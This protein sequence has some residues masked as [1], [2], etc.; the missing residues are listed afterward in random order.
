LRKRRTKL[1]KFLLRF[2][3][4]LLLFSGLSAVLLR[5]RSV[6]TYLAKRAG[7]A[8]GKELGCVVSVGGVEFDLFQ[9]I[10]LQDVYISDQ[11]GD[12]LIFAGAVSAKLKH[13]NYSKRI[14]DLFNV[15]LNR[16]FVHIGRYK[17]IPG[18]NID[19]LV[20]YLNGPPK[21]KKKS[22]KSPWFIKAG[23]VKLV[24]SR[25]HVF[26]Y[27][28]PRPKAGV[29]DD[30]YLEFNNIN[31]VCSDYRMLEDSMHFRAK[32]WALKER[33]GLTIKAMNAVC[34]IHNKGMDFDKLDLK[35]P[36]SH[37][38][39]DLHFK[40]PGFK[41]LD[42]FIHIAEWKANLKNSSV[43][44]AELSI[45]DE[46]LKGHSDKIKISTAISGT[47]DN[48]KL[49]K[50]DAVV[51]E[52]T[53]IKGD[54]LFEGLP[55][56]RTTYC[57][58]D[59]DE[60]S[61]DAQSLSKLLNGT[62]LPS[63]LSRLGEMNYS[64]KFAGQ[65]LDFKL[66]G[67]LQTGL[68]GISVDAFMNFKEGYARAEYAGKFIS[69]GFQA[70][71]LLGVTGTLDQMAFDMD[72]D[73]SGLTTETF[74]MKVNADF[75]MFELR[76]RGYADAEID[77]EI[78]AKNFTGT[79]I[80]DDPRLNTEFGGK[81]DF[82]EA[83]PV[84]DFTTVFKG[85]D[86]YELGIDSTHTLVYGKT[87]V[88][89]RG[90]DPINAEGKLDLENLSVHRLGKVYQY[91]SQQITKV[92]EQAGSSIVC[93][94]DILNGKISGNFDL[95]SLPTIFNNSIARVFPERI[96]PIPYQ[97][98]DSFTFI[99][100]IPETGLFA[101]Y[102]YPSLTTTGF[103]AQG[104]VNTARG[105]LN[106]QTEPLDACINGFTFKHLGF[107]SRLLDSANL[108]FRISAGSLLVNDSAWFN[109]LAL[110]GSACQSRA[111]FE[112]RIND[113]RWG[114]TIDIVAQSV[115]GKDS[116]Q[117]NLNRSTM[118]LFHHEWAA[119]KNA[120]VCI[121]EGGRVKFSELNFNG[122]NTYFELNGF[123]SAR[124]S[125]TLK[126]DF[127]NF[128]FENLKPFIPDHSLDSLD[129]V[130]NGTVY[131]SSL[132]NSPRIWGDIAGRKIKFSGFNYGDIDVS[133]EEHG[134]NG[135]LALNGKFIHGPLKGL[136]AKGSVAYEVRTGEEPLDIRFF[137]PEGT[138]VTAVQPFLKDIL[139]FSQGTLHADVHL[140]GSFSKPALSGF[141]SL[142]D[143][144]FMVDYLKTH[145]TGSLNLN[146]DNK[147]FYTTKPGKL[148]DE[149]GKNHALASL[150]ITHQNFANWYLDVRIDSAKNLKCLNTTAGDDDL[151]YGTGYVDGHCRIYG[152]FDQISMDIKLKT[153]KNTQVFLMY[154]DVEEN[155]VGGFVKFRDHFGKPTGK[156]KKVSSGSIYRINIELQATPDAEAQFVIDRRLGD[157]IRG[158]GEGIIRMLY[159][160][161]GQFF[162]FGNYS[163]TEGD[164]VFSLPGI[165]VLT[166][167]IALNKGGTIAWDGDPFNA[168]LNMT[169]SFEKKI[170][171][172]A[173]MYAVSTGS[174]K[175]YP[176][177]RIVSEL[178][179][180]G[181]LFSPEI[182]FDI[183][184]PDL[185]SGSGAAGSEVYSVIQRIRTDKDETMRQAVSLLLFGN[186][187]P[188]SF[189]SNQGAGVISGS[190]V[191][192]NSLSGI[193][194]SVV[195][196]LFSRLGIPT[197]IQV[198]IDDVRSGN[199][200]KTAVFINSEWFLTERL[201]L[202]LN[203]DP[204][205][206][207][208][209]SNVALPLNFNLEYMTRSEN[210]RI[211][212]FS[213]SNNLLLQQNS[214]TIT[215]GVSGNTLGGGLV[216][217]REFN[218]FRSSSR[219]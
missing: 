197:R 62:E 91:K 1:R 52:N 113:A 207:M 157:I 74:G 95:F 118:N 209:V 26:D 190:G 36:C 169:G 97:G 124:S 76:K 73:G 128:Q 51:G 183:Q 127:G 16:A 45:F 78:T 135:R 83:S 10:R 211:R 189:A 80:F 6:Q 53:R 47:F 184:A 164:Y 187:I 151:Y 37:L 160:E 171:P 41:Y 202:D 142:K 99:L 167:K 66:Q 162:L 106:V 153:R 15:E 152:P 60:A 61:T 11:Q 194:S 130:F 219:K 134:E 44:L 192:G 102:L 165:N 204:T 110:L 58:F 143:S 105:T 20:D 77:G 65:F 30:Y 173:L 144:R 50:L 114:E 172:S 108:D 177:T 208:L 168:M 193:A 86:L 111:D 32:N 185:Q 2:L 22:A 196:D 181:N 138:S 182:S 200:S 154:S 174:N 166:R 119:S 129:G 90:V 104:F 7:T 203:Y 69:Q 206:A 67:L 98:K 112:F 89:F 175:S 123:L 85:L 188:P 213:R 180:K 54:L 38:K 79:A 4:F 93:Q 17:D 48:L 103:I 21:K 101:S 63:V 148:T 19:F 12:T 125:D 88:N 82:T 133:L 191:A 31:G 40:Y 214:S 59:L 94:G 163:V 146:I 39:G 212:A 55:E 155:V 109:N 116:I 131:A 107:S 13:F 159:D 145:Y 64:G 215:N 75:P 68:G 179:M 23:N 100:N 27:R 5:S 126:I 18:N 136:S 87:G 170:S 150:S 205:V 57:D 46:S 210:W 140:G 92:N 70:G 198:N 96:S 176:A 72:I 42:E 149:T 121:N 218:T 147:G 199:G 156:E 81:I 84:F 115:V 56:W 9:N 195:N 3:L 28:K 217:K 161:N 201:R 158:R 25:F 33:S 43:C 122:E 8:L 24:D 29:I 137:L 141:A 34:N 132:F 216:Y 35:M 14:I 186:F 120:S 178:I 71:E 117:M 139:T 49:R